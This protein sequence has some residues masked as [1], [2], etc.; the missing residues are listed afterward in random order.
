M[1]SNRLWTLLVLAILLCADRAFASRPYLGEI[2]AFAA[3]LI[4]RGYLPCDG[5]LLPISSNL[6]L[7]SLLGTRYGGD[8]KATFG[9][10]NLMGRVPIGQGAGQGLSLRD[11]GE[12]V[13]SATV[14]LLNTEMPVHTHSFFYG[15]AP[16]TVNRVDS[17]TV[18]CSCPHIPAYSSSAGNRV[19]MH[20]N[21]IEWAGGNLPHNN[22]MPYLVS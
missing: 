17:T 1:F 10:P 12:E 9:L 20:W 13:G 15:N 11:L 22:M 21:S 18:P 16:G 19:N 7:F 3:W 6:A 4:P 14:T 8:G 5:R 2:R